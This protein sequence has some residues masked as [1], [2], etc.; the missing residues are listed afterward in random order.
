MSCKSICMVSRKKSRCASL[1]LHHSSGKILCPGPTCPTLHMV[2]DEAWTTG[3][4]ATT[5]RSRKRRHNASYQGHCYQRKQPPI[6][7]AHRSASR[8]GQQNAWH[9]MGF[10]ICAACAA[11]GSLPNLRENS[12]NSSRSAAT[13]DKHRARMF[14]TVFNCASSSST[15]ARCRRRRKHS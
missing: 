12:A 1:F 13:Q 9:R 3:N 6:C 14:K 10:L 7:P 4:A 11:H 8:Q 15:D 2:A 5:L